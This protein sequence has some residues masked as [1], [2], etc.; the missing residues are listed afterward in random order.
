AQAGLALALFGP[1]R[2]WAALAGDQPVTSGRNPLH[3]YH[4]G[5]GS[6]T[7]HARGATT[8]YGPSFQ[9][10]YPKTP[11]FDGGCRPA[12]LFLAVSGGDYRPESYKAGLFVCLL[13]IPLAFVVSARGAGLPAGASVLAGAIGSVLG[14]TW[15]VRRLI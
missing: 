3:L 4:G 8:C 6:A 15:P 12:E 11:V 10:G 2:S 13:L 5:L 7:F 1:D 14:W 9:A